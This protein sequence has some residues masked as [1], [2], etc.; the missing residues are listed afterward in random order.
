MN[1]EVNNISFA[2]QN[3]K[4]K[5]KSISIISLKQDYGEI[6]YKGKIPG[7]RMGR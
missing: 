4:R 5:T 2:I 1:T 6:R 3:L 7:T